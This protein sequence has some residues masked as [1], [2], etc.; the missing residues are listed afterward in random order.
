MAL[1]DRYLFASLTLISLDHLI[2]RHLYHYYTL[3]YPSL[4]VSRS[5]ET[6]FRLLAASNA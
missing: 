6:W 4:V 3:F 5:G 2:P 1:T